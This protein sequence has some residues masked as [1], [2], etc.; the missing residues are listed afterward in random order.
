MWY[1]FDKFQSDELDALINQ[2]NGVFCSILAQE[3]YES[4]SWMEGIRL[5]ADFVAFKQAYE[6]SSDEEKE[7]LSGAYNNNIQIESICNLEV[8]PI[9]YEYLLSN[10]SQ[11]FTRCLDILES[12]QDYLYDNLL[13]LSRFTETVGALKNYY[14]QFYNETIYYVCPFC[15]L[16]PMLTPKDY[17][18]EAFDHYLPKSKYPFVSLLRENLFPICHTCNSTY[19]AVKN[20]RDYGKVFYPFTTEPND[21]NCVFTI[22]SGVITSIEINSE[23]FLEEIQTWNEVF[24]IKNRIKNFAE[25]NING[26]MSNVQEAMGNYNV[27]YEYAKNEQINGCNSNKMQGQ[28]FI[29]KAILEAL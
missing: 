18:R 16:G 27:D 24:G 3:A 9:S 25:V 4:P 20:F 26:W 6:L 29:K 7:K 11:Y 14:E 10:A 17:F 15:G 1:F 5:K 8:I 19:K 23:K 2:I 21:C 13:N 28:N 12:I 22:S